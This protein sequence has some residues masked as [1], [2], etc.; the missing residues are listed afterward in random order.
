MHHLAVG[1]EH[2]HPVFPELGCSTN[3]AAMDFIVASFLSRALSR[4][5]FMGVLR[6]LPWKVKALVLGKNIGKL[7]IN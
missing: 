1:A 3:L 5:P 7:V 2:G 4:T 6:D